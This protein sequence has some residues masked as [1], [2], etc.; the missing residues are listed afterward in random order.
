MWILA[1]QCPKS[2]DQEEFGPG[3]IS[4][5]FELVIAKLFVEVQQQVHT[6]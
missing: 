2:K 4:A 5:K 1:D 6:A 3:R